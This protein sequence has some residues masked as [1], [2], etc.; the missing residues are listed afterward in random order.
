MNQRHAGTIPVA[1]VILGLAALMNVPG[2]WAQDAIIIDHNCTDLGQVPAAWIQQA[3]AQLRA[4]YGHTSHGSQVISGMDLIKNPA[5]SLYWWDYSGTQSGLSLW[6]YTPGGDLGAPDYT[7]WAALTRAMLNGY[8][9]DRNVVVWSWCGQADTSPEN[10]QT[11]LNLMAQLRADYPAVKFVYMTGHLVGSGAEGN[12]NQ[13]NNQI[14]AGVQ[15]SGGVLFDFADLESYDP[16]GLWVL[17]LYANDNCD[18]WVGG[19]QHNWASEWCAAH[20]GDP[21]CASCDCAHSQPLNCNRKARAF[22]WMLA[23]I[24]G[25]PG[26][27]TPTACTGDTNCDRRVTFADIDPFVEALAG[28]SAWNQNHPGCP[29]LNADCNGSGTVTF[30]DIDP[31]VAVIG[32][33]CP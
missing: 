3:K 25:W 27:E 17:P 2:A 24:A 28:E 1:V 4:S 15:A 8:G 21:L 18:Y 12:L 13:R 9:A 5:G 30:A 23:R 32:T 31:F 7:A 10:I 20:P 14:R 26:P 16:N 22:W 11:Y 19:V 6:D 29:W 33:T